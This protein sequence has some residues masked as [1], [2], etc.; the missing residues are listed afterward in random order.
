MTN[1]TAGQATTS[2][3]PPAAPLADLLHGLSTVARLAR[4]PMRQVGSSRD[5]AVLHI[6][7]PAAADVA[8]WSVAFGVEDPTRSQSENGATV[9][10]LHLHLLGWDVH[11][12]HNDSPGGTT[13]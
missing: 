6:E 5:G 10:V 11:L 7:V 12:F 3:A 8:R 1:A 9:T 2:A 13:P 4:V